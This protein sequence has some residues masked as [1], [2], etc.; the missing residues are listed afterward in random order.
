M[1]SSRLRDLRSDLPAGLVVFLVALPLC[2]GIALASGAPLFAGLIAG[3]VGGLVIP[4][5]S[6]S[7]L[8]VSGP[9]AG[10]AAVVLAGIRD[11]GMEGLAAAVLVAGIFQVLLGVARAGV[12]IQFMPASVIKGM[13]TAIGIL[14]ILKQIPHAIGFDVEKFGAEAFDVGD[15][16]NTFTVFMEAL[17]DFR[18][19]ALLISA[20]AIPTLVLWDRTRITFL[21]AALVVVVVGTLLN[22]SYG[23]WMP[24]LSL[25]Q[26]HLVTLP[27]GSL[28]EQVHS[29]PVRALLSAGV[30]K[31]AVT[32][33]IVASLESMLSIEAIDKLDPLK[34]KTPMN[35]ELIAQG[36]GNTVSGVLGGL[37][38]TSV[39]VRSSANV[40]AGARSQL[41]AFTH[42]AFMLLAVVFARD[43]L[44]HIPLA[45]L[46][47]ILVVTGYKLAKPALF[48]EMYRQGMP[49]F[50]PFMVTIT[51][52]IF[53]DLLRGIVI[54]MASC[55]LFMRQPV[56]EQE[57]EA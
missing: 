45:A 35:R 26:S 38:V 34:R 14:L 46:A 36:V 41:S 20:V 19:G 54:G 7:A 5:V 42:G 57:R 48:R 9:A 51:G 10:L 55:V 25:A 16:E 28:V 37:P 8:S 6:R 23:S 39:I 15:G 43:L 11:V 27:G 12:L 21:P 3:M 50:V 32:L 1:L 17:L 33:A 53:T 18:G 22:L 44:Q 30:W 24:S 31:L 56:T 47:S 40:N 2:L 49:V 4:L 52:I 29:P 13:L